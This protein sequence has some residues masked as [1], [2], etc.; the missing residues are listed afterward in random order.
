MVARR[1]QLLR[2]QG[3]IGDCKLSNLYAEDIFIEMVSHEDLFCHIAKRKM[4]DCECFMGGEG[5]EG[6]VQQGREQR[7]VC[8]EVHTL[9]FG[10]YARQ[11]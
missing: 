4:A 1:T 11:K 8:A 6:V 7:R 2:S 3:E 10:P 9:H 5:G